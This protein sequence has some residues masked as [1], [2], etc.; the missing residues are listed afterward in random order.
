MSKK[1]IQSKIAA[2]QRKEIDPAGLA[3]YTE[4]LHVETFPRETIMIQRRQWMIGFGILATAMA[5]VFATAEPA[6]ESV[7]PAS[8]LPAL[9]ADAPAEVEP[10]SFIVKDA[11][12][13]PFSCEVTYIGDGE[14]VMRT[15]PPGG[16]WET[17]AADESL[18]ITITTLDPGWTW[19][20]I[21]AEIGQLKR[22]TLTLPDLTVK[23]IVEFTKTWTG[24]AELDCS[25]HSLSN[26]DLKQLSLCSKIC[27]LI[28]SDNST[29]TDAGLVH[30]KSL[31]NLRSLSLSTIKGVSDAG[32]AHLKSIK[33][34]EY[35]GLRE[36]AITD[37]G[38]ALLR[39]MANLK[40][41]NLNMTKVTD[42]GLAHL[43]SSKTLES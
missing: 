23:Q 37:A 8:K 11:I 1:T 30:L 42:A 18:R 24:Q 6:A 4:I 17:P 39:D 21:G 32:L 13:I 9:S 41:L 29:V 12:Y 43:K 40:T 26:A 34:L 25:E 16:G 20:R 10:N 31:P 38:L 7:A 28:L 22:P 33:T 2:T 19:K 35:L 3:G 36:T 15:L 5:G 27:G 14:H